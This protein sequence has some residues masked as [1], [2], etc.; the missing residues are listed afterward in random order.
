MISEQKLEAATDELAGSG[1]RK[2]SRANIIAFLAPLAPALEAGGENVSIDLLVELRYDQSVAVFWY[3]MGFQHA[4]LFVKIAMIK[5]G[6]YWK[7][8]RF[9]FNDDFEKIGLP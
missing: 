7:A 5:R 9:S 1:R 8:L 4:D 3:F 6:E 2:V